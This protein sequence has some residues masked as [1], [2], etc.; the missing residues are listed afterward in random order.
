MHPAPATPRV[1]RRPPRNVLEVRSRGQGDWT[2]HASSAAAVAKTP[3]LTASLLAGLLQDSAAAFEAEYIVDDDGDDDG[4][5]ASDADA[6]SDADVE[7]DEGK[8]SRFTGVKK[9]ANGTF[10]ARIKVDGCLE[11]I[12]TFDDEKEA[13]RIYDEQAALLGR[14]VNFPL[15]EGMEQAVKQASK[16]TPVWRN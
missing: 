10:N 14:S 11:H 13:A 15:H 16:G 3:G 1:S 2:S 7:G 12:G 9:R 6:A 4:R 8:K 5:D